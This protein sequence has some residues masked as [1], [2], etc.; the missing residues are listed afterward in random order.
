MESR[1]EKSLIHLN[2]QP[3]FRIIYLEHWIHTSFFQ[4]AA[5]P[6]PAGEKE[7]ACGLASGGTVAA[8]WVTKQGKQSCDGLEKLR[9]NC[10]CRCS[11]ITCGV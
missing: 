1:Q 11:P 3:N 8:G 4:E 10:F 2:Y 9:A 7:T 5:P 6:P